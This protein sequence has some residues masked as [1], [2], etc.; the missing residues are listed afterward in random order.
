MGVRWYTGSC[1]CG[2]VTFH[3]ELDLEAEQA[4]GIRPGSYVLIRPQA[5]SLIA[6]DSDLADIQFGTVIGLNRFCK[7]CGVRVFGIGHLAKLGGEFC[8]VS[9]PA[10]DGVLVRGDAELGA[11][12]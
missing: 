8:A 7:H 2:R 4:K 5:F 1:Q 10:L 3:A 12:G 11:A 6:G 9:L